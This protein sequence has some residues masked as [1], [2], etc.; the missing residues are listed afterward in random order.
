MS[1]KTLLL[2]IL[3]FI[4]FSSILISQTTRVIDKD[5]QFGG[6]SKSSEYS[7]GQEVNGVHKTIKFFDK[8]GNLRKKVSYYSKDNKLQ[9]WLLNYEKTGRIVK[10]EYYY[11]KFSSDKD[12]FSKIYVFI[13]KKGNKKAEYYLT[14]KFSA[15]KGYDKR[16]FYLDKNRNLKKLEYFKNDV[17]LP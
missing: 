1:Y 4:S 12:G 2:L 13:D 6:L 10:E 16:V 5:N 14:D 15:E 11:N 17:R 7:T 9:K 3:F 8:S